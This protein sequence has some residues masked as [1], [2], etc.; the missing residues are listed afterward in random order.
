MKNKLSDRIPVIGIVG[1][2]GPAAGV[3]LSQKIIMNTRART[4]QDHLPQILYT[5][6]GAI[7]DRTAFLLGK[8]KVNPC[9]AIVDILVKLESL[10]ATV[11]GLPCNSAHASP[12]F[13][14]IRK[15]LRRRKSRLKLLD[16]IDEV[17][18][19]IGSEFPGIKKAGILGT[20]GIFLA[21]PY[22]RIAENG[23]QAVYLSNESQQ[24]LHGAIYQI[25]AQNRADEEVL[26]IVRFSIKELGAN[27]AEVVVLACTE[28]ALIS[29]AQLGSD[30][31]VVNSTTALAR[32]LI[33][34]VAPWKLLPYAEK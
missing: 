4:D 2:M 22:D 27:G 5:D 26:K 15:V 7:G 9:F 6:A 23:L 1:G 31:P 33:R 16:M 10:G 28:L 17:A 19:F 29:P 11:A 14:C 34:T 3:D 20:T 32:G 8:N 25:K 12:I 13:D 24:R 18:F 21:K 30:I